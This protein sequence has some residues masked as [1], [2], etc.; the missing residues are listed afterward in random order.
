MCGVRYRS[1]PAASAYWLWLAMEA[2]YAL[3][4]NK[5]GRHRTQGADQ[6]TAA[7]LVV[8]TSRMNKVRSVVS[9]TLTEWPWSPQN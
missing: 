6:P 3:N 8:V 7:T 4:Q 2:L 9:V 1:L 5:I